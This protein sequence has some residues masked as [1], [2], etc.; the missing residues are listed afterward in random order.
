MLIILGQGIYNISAGIMIVEK[1]SGTYCCLVVSD[2]NEYNFITDD[3]ILDIK[4]ENS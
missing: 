4:T 1:N 2:A 3:T